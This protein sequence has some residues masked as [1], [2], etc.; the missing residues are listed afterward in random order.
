[1]PYAFSNVA[2]DQLRRRSLLA[3]MQRL[4]GEIYLQD[5]AIRRSDL[6]PDGR[7]ELADDESAWHLLLLDERSRVAG[8]MRFLRYDSTAGS[9]RLGVWHSALAQTDS[10]GARLRR[11]VN[12]QVD[13][14]CREG[15]AIGE[16]GGW[17]LSPEMRLSTA[18][19][20]MVL[21]TYSLARVLGNAL[22]ISTATLRNGS[23][24]I[25]RRIGGCSLGLDGWELPTY[26]DPKYNCEMQIL[27][28]DS[29][30]PNARYEESVDQL[31]R[32]LMSVPVVSARIG[33]TSQN[34]RFRVDALP[35]MRPVLAA[36]AR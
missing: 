28:F 9:P 22:V 15:L 3:E 27:R 18:A 30:A 12:A 13:Q 23:A 2:D 24:P 16:A 31:R 20:R 33:S 26:F 35:L 4:R 10:W 34:A 6:T 1:M 14:A 17:A 25:L 36:A 7:H 5:G 11:A 29:R 19:L 8:C 32:H 21:A